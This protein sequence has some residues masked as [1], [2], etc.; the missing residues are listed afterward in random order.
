V[1]R[2]PGVV[3]SSAWMVKCPYDFEGGSQKFQAEWKEE[4]EAKRKAYYGKKSA[5]GG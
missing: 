5:P 3:S 2:T 1:L 4:V